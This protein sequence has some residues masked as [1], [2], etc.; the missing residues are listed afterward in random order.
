[1]SENNTQ[2]KPTVQVATY[3]LLDQ[4]RKE[5]GPIAKLVAPSEAPD[6]PHPME[7]VIELLKALT[8]G[9]EQIW[10]S[11]GDT[12]VPAGRSS[13][14]ESVEGRRSQLIF[15]LGCAAQQGELLDLLAVARRTAQPPV[16]RVVSALDEVIEVN[17]ST[18]KQRRELAEPQSLVSAR[19]R[20]R[21]IR[22]RVR[23]LEAEA[24]TILEKLAS[25]PPS[26]AWRRFWYRRETKA[27]I[28]LNV[29][30]SKKQDHVRKAVGE[31]AWSQ[32]QLN[33]E[34]KSFQSAR[35]KH[36]QE[37]LER[38][39]RS[40]LEMKI[41]GQAKVFV[42]KNPQFALWGAA[43]LMQVAAKIEQARMEFL[44]STEVDL[45][46]QENMSTTP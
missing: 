11:L 45:E 13:S 24:G 14:D 42:Q 40:K 4:L 12:G 20:E 30:L 33:A 28:A 35:V 7:A 18:M 27:R 36:D 9:V 22:L 6:Q 17:T 21:E 26:T 5:M 44:D 3:R 15:M 34:I 25:F 41:A 29:A 2:S 39:E 10:G 43:H 38:A 16:E 23:A 32:H 19:G 8:G 1:M 31:H 37:V 46:L